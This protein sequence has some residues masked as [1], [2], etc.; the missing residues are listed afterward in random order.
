[1]IRNSKI[2]IFYWSERKIQ[3]RP[4]ENYGDLLSKYLVEKIT[5]SKLKWINPQKRNL[6]NRNNKV[7]FII[8]SIL[9]FADQNTV[10]WGSGIISKSLEVKEAVFTAVRGPETRTFL[11]DKGYKVPE[12]YGDPALLL[13][14]YF[15]P[16]VNKKYKL[17]VIPHHVDYRQIE[18]WYKNDDVLIIDLLT[19]DIEFTTQQI[20]SCELTISSSLHGIIVSHAYNIPSLWMQCSDKIFG[21]NIK[22]KDYLYSVNLEYYDPINCYEKIEVGDLIKTVKSHKFSTIT[23]ETLTKIQN[24]L[25]N[26]CPL[27]IC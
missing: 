11:L 5:N 8:G 6:F 26:A 16:T 23:L 2:N 14:K 20:M 19:N 18:Q 24:D 21:D 15:N 3:K 10:V 13:P 1:M 7:Y 25:L 4:K 27:P 22:Y 12:I 17:G 9:Q